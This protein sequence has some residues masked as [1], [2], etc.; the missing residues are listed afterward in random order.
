V[1]APRLRSQ[2]GSR[3]LV[4]MVQ[5]AQVFDLG[6]AT[7][8]SRMNVS[9]SWAVHVQPL[10]RA[11]PVVVVEVAGEDAP[12]VSLVEHDHVIEALAADRADKALDEWIL[13]WRL[14]GD[15]DFFDADVPHAAT[16]MLAV[17]AVAMYPLGQP[18]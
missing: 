17:D 5:T 15:D 9:T 7:A 2:S 11:P 13:P 4:V 16:E 3:P 1:E 12:Q 8:L 18:M 6:D 10:M 14:G